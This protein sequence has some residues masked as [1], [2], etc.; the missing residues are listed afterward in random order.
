MRKTLF[1]LAIMFLTISDARSQDNVLNE[2]VGIKQL[3][4]NATKG[5][6]FILTGDEYI[7]PNIRRTGTFFYP[8][9]SLETGSIYYNGYLY[10]DI[11][12]QWDIF[13]NYVLTLAG[14]GTSKIILR[15]D[16]IDSFLIGHHRIIK[17]NEDRSKNLYN[18]DF[19][20]VLYRGPVSVFARRQKVAEQQ[21]DDNKVVYNLRDEDK[22]YLEKDGIFYRV[23]R[24]NDVL[25]V[26]TRY[27][28]EINRIINKENL[29]WKKQFELCLVAAATSINESK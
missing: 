6:S 13:S 7:F 14:S 20:E 21:N 25:N 24:K 22:Y 16:L 10:T 12:L 3:Y 5:S 27:R 2:Y 4:D 23:S 8:S 19:Y 9:D 18:T 28:T 17:M 26:F 15:N 11:P 29:N 1:A